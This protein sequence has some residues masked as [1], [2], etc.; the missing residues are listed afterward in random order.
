MTNYIQDTQAIATLNR[1]FMAYFLYYAE[2]LGVDFYNTR[3]T[4]NITK[5]MIGHSFVPGVDYAHM[6]HFEMFRICI[7]DVS[8]EKFMS[9]GIEEFF[10]DDMKKK[11]EMMAQEFSEIAKKYPYADYIFSSL[12]DAP[13]FITSFDKCEDTNFSARM[14]FG[15]NFADFKKSV[16]FE[17]YCLFVQRWRKVEDST[18]YGEK[19]Q[20]VE[21]M[22]PEEREKYDKQPEKESDNEIQ[23]ERTNAK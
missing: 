22:T 11:V 14:I 7:Q 9:S 18:I 21:S 19:I 6:H 8:L 10:D 15:P 23:N 3:P 1:V 16:L 2:K 13:P 12:P 4:E 17:F 5:S 20:T